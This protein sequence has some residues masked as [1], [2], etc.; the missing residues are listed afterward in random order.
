MKIICLCAR[1]NS[2]SVACAYVLKEKGHEALAAGMYSTSRAT[3]KMLYEW[4]DII[5]LHLPSIKHWIP[6]EYHHKVR[7]WD[8]GKDIFFRDFDK[9]LK[10]TFENYIKSEL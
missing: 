7:V 10:Q 9:G 4:A 5:I 2:R 3:R 1:G 6:E 8:V